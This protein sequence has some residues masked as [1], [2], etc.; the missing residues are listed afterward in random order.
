MQNAIP[1]SKDLNP[2]GCRNHF[3][4]SGSDAEEADEPVLF[5]LWR[6][7]SWDPPWKE[8]R[9]GVIQLNSQAA[10]E[11]LERTF[12]QQAQPCVTQR[13]IS[14]G[15]L[16]QLG[17]ARQD[18]SDW[19]ENTVTCRVLNSSL[20]LELFSFLFCWP[21]Y[22][23]LGTRSFSFLVGDLHR[24]HFPVPLQP[25]GTVP[26]PAMLIVAVLCPV[27]AQPGAVFISP[28]HH[29][30]NNPCLFLS[31]AQSCSVSTRGTNNLNYKVFTKLVG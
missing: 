18:T 8:G 5:P 24:G 29:R 20:T 6:E 13:K 25:T 30:G 31:T 3:P 23:P 16:I 12:V 26:L 4:V 14:F 11:H 15:A 27:P 1:A 9:A 2:C 28:E 22:E 17:Q 7:G 10:P 19:F 21:R